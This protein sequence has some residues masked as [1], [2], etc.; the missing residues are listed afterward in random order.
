MRSGRMAIAALVLWA[1]TVV[2]VGVTFYRSHRTT[3]VSADPRAVIALSSPTRD[4]V[5]AEM[6]V[7]LVSVNEILSAA[8]RGDTAALRAAAAASGTAQAMATL[9]AD[10][11]KEFRS[12]AAGTHSL[13]DS[14]AAA[15][16]AGAPRDTVTARLA[17]LTASCTACHVAY[18][19]VA[20]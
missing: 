10:L 14:L 13:F 1:V 3:H 18:R 16:A 2:A 6:R 5:L 12:R 17:R 20:R 4:A 7:M 9:G 8:A 19:L 15:V 11:P